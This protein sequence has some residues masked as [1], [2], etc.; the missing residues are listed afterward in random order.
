[1]KKHVVIVLVASTAA[2]QIVVWILGVHGWVPREAA[3]IFRLVVGWG[4]I[5]ILAVLASRQI[6]VLETD[7]RTQQDLNR[8]TI[9]QVEELATLNEMLVTLGQSKDV[10]L[11]FQSLARRVG[12]LVP[13]DRLGLALVRESGQD[14]LTYSARV[15]EPERRRRPRPELEFSLERSICGE[16]VRTC[17]TILLTD[18]AQHASDFHDASALS[19]Q[20]FQSALVLPLVSRNRAIGA[21]MLISRQHAAFTTAHREA[22]QPLAEVLAFAYLAQRQHLAL[23]KFETMETM[24][25][26]TIAMASEINGALQSVIGEGAILRKEHPEL[27]AGL[28]NMVQQAERISALLERMRMA[29]HDRRGDGDAGGAIPASPEGFGRDQPFS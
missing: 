26:M 22:M 1:M 27:G 5:L 2:L 13:C 29:A 15:S 12:R 18:L 3:D 10:G 11:A 23:E 16:V 19:S 4:L 14:V 20:G 6:A 21:L 7:L 25:E 9:D 8:A 24:S 17:E 28:D